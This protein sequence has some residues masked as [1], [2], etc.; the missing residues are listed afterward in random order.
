MRIQYIDIT[1]KFRE[2]LQEAINNRANVRH[3]TVTKDEM[4]QLVQHAKAAEYLPDYMQPREAE[5]RQL[6]G[7]KNKLRGDLE[8]TRTQ[9][10]KQAIFDKMSDVETRI[11][12]MQ[13]QV[14]DQIRQSG[15]LIRV[16][17]TA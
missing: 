13:Q 14:P 3:I 8:H 6:N 2:L 1:Q 7:Q 5:M 10:E 15:I 16:G 12:A 9:Q 4:R 17:M 11:L